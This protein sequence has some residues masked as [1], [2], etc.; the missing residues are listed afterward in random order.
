MTARKPTKKTPFKIIRAT[1]SPD[2]RRNV[3]GLFRSKGMKVDV[4]GLLREVEGWL[5]ARMNLQK[6]EPK[7]ADPQAKRIR[8]DLRALAKTL[9][10]LHHATKERLA[11]MYLLAYPMPPPYEHG[12]PPMKRAPGRPDEPE[13][14][15]YVM[16]K[17]LNQS[18]RSHFLRFDKRGMAGLPVP[19]EELTARLLRTCELTEHFYRPR[20]G[21]PAD[22]DR[23]MFAMYIMHAFERFTGAEATSAP[24]APFDTFLGYILEDAAGE[25]TRETRRKLIEAAD[26]RRRKLEPADAEL[27][28]HYQAASELWGE[29]RANRFMS[30][31]VLPVEARTVE[32]L[33]DRS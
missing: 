9:N 11:D 18:E 28:A 26:A 16:T 30:S 13:A 20:K 24:N 33:L 14:K 6:K 17:V 27:V 31:H 8:Q 19:L 10:T 25:P 4:P 29:E 12:N 1:L 23:T 21:A 7:T 22:H 3:E 2:C 5:I 15:R 32:R